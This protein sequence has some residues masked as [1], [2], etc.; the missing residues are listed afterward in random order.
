MQDDP[1]L[2]WHRRERGMCSRP[3][4]NRPIA[5]WCDTC[6]QRQPFHVGQAPKL[7]ESHLLAHTTAAGHTPYWQYGAPAGSP[8]PD[9]GGHGGGAA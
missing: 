7:C 8:D 9:D 5:G 6:D 1:I 3:T 2:D 4:C